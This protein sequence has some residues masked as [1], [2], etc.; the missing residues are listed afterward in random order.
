MCIKGIVATMDGWVR[1]MCCLDREKIGQ[2]V[3]VL[4]A[5]GSADI[6][7]LVPKGRIDLTTRRYEH[8]RENRICALSN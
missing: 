5:S 1:D 3:P 2:E 4:I 8:N 7:Q 6:I